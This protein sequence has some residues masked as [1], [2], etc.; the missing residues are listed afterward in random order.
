[1]H[2]QRI[3]GTDPDNHVGVNQ[4]TLETLHDDKDFI[5]VFDIHLN[6]LNGRHM[7]VA[8]GYDYAMI[9]GERT[10]GTDQRAA[11]KVPAV[12]PDCRITPGIPSLRESVMEISSC[13]SFGMDLRWQ[14][15]QRSLSVPGWSAALGQQIVPAGFKSA[16]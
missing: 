14:R 2:G 15:F 9:N 5:V 16:L 4:R 12:S 13:V 11:G 7:D 10:I 3:I 8:F 1:M 6:R